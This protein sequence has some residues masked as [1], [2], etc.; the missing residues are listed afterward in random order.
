MTAKPPYHPVLPH[1]KRKRHPLKRK[2]HPPQPSGRNEECHKA[3]YGCRKEKHKEYLSG[4]NAVI[5]QFPLHA[6]FRKGMQS[7]SGVRGS[8]RLE[9]CAAP[10][11]EHQPGL[12]VKFLQGTLLLGVGTGIKHGIKTVSACGIEEVGHGGITPVN[13]QTL[14]KPTILYLHQRQ[15]FPFL[16]IQYQRSHGLLRTKAT[17][18]LGTIQLQHYLAGNGG[19]SGHTSFIHHLPYGQRIGMAARYPGHPGSIRRHR[20]TAKQHYGHA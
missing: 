11:K 4:R 3:D 17:I 5:E 10:E 20:H 9:E 1:G 15:G 19:E 8:I 12:F 13:P 16:G 18:G 2:R 14:P 6:C 7:G